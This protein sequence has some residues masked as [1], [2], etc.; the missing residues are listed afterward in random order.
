M[1]LTIVGNYHLKIGTFNDWSV[2][3]LNALNTAKKNPKVRNVLYQ[4]AVPNIFG[5]MDK[6]HG[7]QFFQGQ[8]R[9]RYGFGMIQAHYIYC[10]LFFLLSLHHLHLRSSGI[11]SWSLGTLVLYHTPGRQTLEIFKKKKKVPK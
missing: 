7:K 11:R 3:N 9:E 1:N 10:V 6:F 8:V 5:T 2:M 4:P